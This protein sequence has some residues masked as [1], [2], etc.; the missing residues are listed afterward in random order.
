ML[1]AVDDGVG[2]IT[3]T[4]KKHGLTERTLIW[5]IGDNGAPLKIHKIDSPLD[6]DAGGWD[7]SLNTPLNGEKGMLSEGGM[8]VPFLIAWPGTIPAS[9]TYDHPVSALD[10]AARSGWRPRPPSGRCRATSSWRSS[11]RSAGSSSRS[12][13]SALRDTPCR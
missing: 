2:L 10:V 4:L 11:S 3:S 9:Q 1:S 12:R 13:R 5:F 8:H 6:G 7:G